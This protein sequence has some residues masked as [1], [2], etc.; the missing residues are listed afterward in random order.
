MA[1]VQTRSLDMIYHTNFSTTLNAAGKKITPIYLC[2]NITIIL[3][4]Q[5]TEKEVKAFAFGFRNFDILWK[6]VLLT[7]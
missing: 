4:S 7:E 2:N 3:H 5:H 1:M 6:R